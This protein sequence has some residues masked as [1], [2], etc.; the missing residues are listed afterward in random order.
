MEKIKKFNQVLL[1]VIGSISLLIIIGIGISLLV[2]AIR[3]LRHEEVSFPKGIISEEKTDE[4]LT[5]SLRK[6]II[7][8]DKIELIDSAG[9]IFLLPVGQANLSEEEATSKLLGLTNVYRGNWDNIGYPYES[10][11]NNLIL[12]EA[13]DSLSTLIFKERISISDYK[14]IARGTELD[15]L[16]TGTNRDSNGNG[17]V[18]N[19]DL[20]NLFLYDLSL[21]L[22]KK[23]ETKSQMGVLSA[24]KYEGGNEVII[25]YGVDRNENGKFDYAEEPKVYYLLDVDQARLNQIVSSPQINQLQTLLEGGK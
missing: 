1:A 17:Y 12:F 24:L 20:Q 21:R 18:E 8:F 23:I 5:D 10:S 15:L 3:N 25:Q 6:Q 19:S 2:D 9:R 14:V 7:S 4:L 13:K 11:Y 22:V 16:I